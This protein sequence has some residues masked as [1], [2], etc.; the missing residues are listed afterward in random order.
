[1][2]NT[3]V[4][5]PPS[6]ESKNRLSASNETP[7][8][9]LRRQEGIALKFIHLTDTHLVP[10]GQT[11]CALDPALRLQ[12]TVESINRIHGDAQFVVHT[13][14]LSYHGGEPA[15]HAM[16]QILAQLRMPYH[17]LIGNHDDRETFRRV[18][19]SVPVDDAGFVQYT[20]DTPVGVFVMLDS[21][22]DGQEHGVLCEKRLAWLAREL[23]RF[24][25]RAVFLFMHHPPFDIGIRSLDASRLRQA[26]PLYELLRSHGN[27]RHLFYGHVHRAIG[28]S[29]RGIPATTLPGTNHQ[30]ALYMGPDPTLIG[31]HEASAYGV[32]L[33]DEESV[34]VH[35][36][37][38]L[39]ESPR[40]VLSDPRSKQAASVGDLVAPPALFDGAL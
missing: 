11:L 34:A 32:C 35:F 29:W 19:P 40:F 24:H 25:Q 3:H 4:G 2:L 17:L 16:A 27:V 23:Q 12:A 39:D 22:E 1:M 28:G 31:S 10:P 38:P 14:D 15:Y 8:R 36:H 30:V 5:K 6:I 26:A 33:I 7:T 21:V 9:R 20:V 37:D 13:G 18:F